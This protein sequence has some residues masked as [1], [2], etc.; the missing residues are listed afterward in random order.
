MQRSTF[1]RL[2]LWLLTFF[3]ASL[4]FYLLLNGGAY[5]RILRYHIFLESPFASAELTGADIFSI[6]GADSAMAKSGGA[7]QLIVPKISVAVPVAIPSDSSKTGILASLE[8]GVGLYPG[9][10]VFGETG[11]SILLGHSSRATWYRG[12]YATIFA[13]LPELKEFDRFYIAGNGKKYTYEVFSKKILTPQETNALLATTPG[14]SEVDLVTCYPIG[15][16]SKR[17]VVQAKLVKTESI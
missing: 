14:D 10:G 1:R 4:F 9:S 13:L 8:E 6:P 17:T 5:W 7:Y 2:N 12:E 15:S 3:G 11:R 16:A